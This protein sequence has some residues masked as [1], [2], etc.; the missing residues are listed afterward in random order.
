MTIM[1]I[2]LYNLNIFCSD[3]IQLLTNTDPSLQTSSG[4]IKRLWCM[5][6]CVEKHLKESD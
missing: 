5:I 3:T 2:S 1:V 6:K 4:V